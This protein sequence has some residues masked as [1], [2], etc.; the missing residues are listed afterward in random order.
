[1]HIEY[2]KLSQ[3]PFHTHSRHAESHEVAETQRDLSQ[4]GHRFRS[5]RRDVPRISRPNTGTMPVHRQTTTMRRKSCL[6]E[7][8]FEIAG[9]SSWSVL[10]AHSQF[11]MCRLHLR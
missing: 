5:K 1:M 2:L 6:E 10:T 9:S 11:W 8:K 7:G 4:V 3:S